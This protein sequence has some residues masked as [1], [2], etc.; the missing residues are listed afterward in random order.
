MGCTDSRKGRGI[1]G[2][3]RGRGQDK[4]PGTQDVHEWGTSEAGRRGR[5]GG[6]E[7]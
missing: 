7:R 3:W 6:L 1:H 2:V 4:G 5:N